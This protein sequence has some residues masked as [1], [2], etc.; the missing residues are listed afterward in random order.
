M[1]KEKCLYMAGTADEFTNSLPEAILNCTAEIKRKASNPQFMEKFRLLLG[2]FVMFSGL[3][4]GLFTT[5]VG[6]GLGFLA[7]MASPFVMVSD[8]N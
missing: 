3:Y 2:L 7:M 4:F 1:R 6:E 5:G 8:K